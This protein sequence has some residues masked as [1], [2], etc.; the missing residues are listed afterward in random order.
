[1]VGFRL[2]LSW[3]GVVLQGKDW[4]V[5]PSILSIERWGG[6]FD[7]PQGR[8]AHTLHEVCGVWLAFSCTCPGKGWFYRGRNGPFSRAFSVSE[9]GGA[10]ST[11]PRGE[12]LTLRGVWLGFSCAGPGKGRFCE[13]GLACFSQRC[14][15]AALS[16]TWREDWLPSCGAWL[17]FSSAGPGKG[18]LRVTKFSYAGQES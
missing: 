2:Y 13:L 18:R 16:A 17:G 3:K 8:K 15:V 9:D 6:S 12:R 11:T 4:T 5:F 14:E 1:M 7:D 10:L